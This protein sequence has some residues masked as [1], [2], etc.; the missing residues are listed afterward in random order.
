MTQNVIQNSVPAGGSSSSSG[1]DEPVSP[2]K[3]AIKA[4]VSVTYALQ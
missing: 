4:E 3:I 2:G 1:E